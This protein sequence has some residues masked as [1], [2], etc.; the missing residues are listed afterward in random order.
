[1]SLD[2]ESAFAQPG[3]TQRRRYTLTQTQDDRH[4]PQAA[5]SHDEGPTDDEGPLSP[6]LLMAPPL[7]RG[8]AV[9]YQLEIALDRVSTVLGLRW[10]L[11]SYITRLGVFLLKLGTLGRP[12]WPYVARLEVSI[13]LVLVAAM[14]LGLPTPTTNLAMQRSHSNQGGLAPRDVPSTGLGT[15]LILLALHFA[16]LWTARRWDTLCVSIPRDDWAEW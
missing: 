16:I 9:R 13:P 12:C 3:V 11:L 14:D 7:T 15:S 4:D 2:S 6:P 8:G 10:E 5:S 1:M